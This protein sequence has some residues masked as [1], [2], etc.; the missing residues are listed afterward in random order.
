MLTLMFFTEKASIS[1]LTGDDVPNSEAK[2]S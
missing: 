1:D 2:L